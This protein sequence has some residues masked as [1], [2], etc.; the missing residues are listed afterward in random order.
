MVNEL[1]EVQEIL[2]GKH[3]DRDYLF[4]PCFMLAKWY[5]QQGLSYLETRIKIFEWGKK[6]NIYIDCYLAHIIDK[7]TKDKR[8][9]RGED[10][11]VYINDD[12]IAEIER[13]F[14]KRCGNDRKTALAL[15]CYAKASA[16]KDGVIYLPQTALAQWLDIPRP[17]LNSRHLKNLVDLEYI[18]RLDDK[19]TGRYARS[20]WSKVTKDENRIYQKSTEFQMLVP[21]EN[22]GDYKLEDNNIQKLYE[23]VFRKNKKTI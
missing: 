9:L 3:I 5:K 20:A 14:D 4:R 13:R 15:L 17:N 1:I 18:K 11:V 16:D 7:A 12:D 19:T 10:T 8:P 22:N 6:Y 23:E 21:L 2:D